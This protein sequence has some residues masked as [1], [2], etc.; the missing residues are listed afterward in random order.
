MQNIP[1]RTVNHNICKIFPFF[2][3]LLLLK[4]MLKLFSEAGEMTK[5]HSDYDFLKNVR[6]KI[7]NV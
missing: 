1:R 2:F 5:L 4:K 6:M 3:L 7:E